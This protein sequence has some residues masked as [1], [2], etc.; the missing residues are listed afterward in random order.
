M[1][2]FKSSKTV[3]DEKYR[4]SVEK[5]NSMSN[6]SSNELSRLT[7]LVE[8]LEFELSVSKKTLEETQIELND[9]SSRHD[10]LVVENAT[11]MVDE[12]DMNGLQEKTSSL[13]LEISKLEEVIAKNELDIEEL[14][15]NLSSETRKAAS[16][17]VQLEEE[18]R[19]RNSQAAVIR[20]AEATST[21]S[22]SAVKMDL[23]AANDKITN[24]KYEAV[25]LQLNLDVALKDSSTVRE[26][27][28]KSEQD[29]EE[30]IS[31]LNIL[32]ERYVNV[33]QDA[34]LKEAEREYLKAEL[35]RVEGSLAELTALLKDQKSADSI[36][37]ELEIA[38]LNAKVIEK[39]RQSALR[40]ADVLRAECSR[41]LEDRR[42]SEIRLLAMEKKVQAGMAAQERVVALE[43]LLVSIRGQSAKLQEDLV[44]IRGQ[45]RMTLENAKA[46]VTKMIFER[47]TE[48]RHRWDRADTNW[49]VK[50]PGG[51]V[52]VAIRDSA[53]RVTLD[54]QH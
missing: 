38:Y 44:S 22:L 36:Q 12:A 35:A 43:N 15:R 42:V 4:E 21:A 2:S 49:K 1:Q 41:L 9:L 28:S 52:M 32:N 54:A 18:R 51:A 47:L 33:S 30:L 53:H 16:L 10:A 31:E 8:S 11:L 13:Q 14:K 23:V 29:R 27:L 7:K 26:L 45:V 34:Q 40:E 5:L 17:I 3:I 20:A 24:L 48:Y 6:E 25:T 50:L 46:E 37:K 39:Q 19:D